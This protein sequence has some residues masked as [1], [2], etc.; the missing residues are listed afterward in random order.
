M[1]KGIIDGDGHICEPPVVWNEDIEKRDR[2]DAI[3]VERDPDGRDWISIDGAMRRK[4]RPA[5]ACVPWG[6]DD[7]NKVPSWEDI[8]PG[9]YDGGSVGNTSLLRQQSAP[10][11]PPS[12]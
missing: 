9:F 10:W 4:L 12:P 11:W 2:A 6:M 5:A 7:P 3:R 8:L 1:T